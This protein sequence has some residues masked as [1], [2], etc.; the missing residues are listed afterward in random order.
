M[1]MVFNGY[2][3][4]ALLATGLATSALI[5][6]GESTWYEGLQLLALYSVIG[7]VFYVA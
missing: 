7:I 1:G 4:A 2:E 5:S 6:S 3:L